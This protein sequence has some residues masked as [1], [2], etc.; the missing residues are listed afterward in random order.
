MI[1]DP[2]GPSFITRTVGRRRYADDA[3]VSH[4][5]KETWAHRGERLV[6]PR[7]GHYDRSCI[8]KAPSDFKRTRTSS[9]TTGMDCPVKSKAIGI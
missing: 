6:Q 4:D 8:L 1:A 9:S 2:E 7:R 3:S 5:P